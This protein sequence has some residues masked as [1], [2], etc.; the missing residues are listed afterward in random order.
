[1][2]RRYLLNSIGTLSLLNFGGTFASKLYAQES[3]LSGTPI[4]NIK[5]PHL[6]QDA[7]APVVFYSPI[8]SPDALIKLLEVSQYKVS[9]KVGIKMTFSN[10]RD[11]AV[12]IDPMLI[13]PLIEKVKGTMIDSNYFDGA[14]NNTQAHLE[15]AKANG[16]DKAGPIEILD[17]EGEIELPVKGGYHLKTFITGS[18]LADYDSLISVVRFKGHNLPRYGGSMKNLSICLGTPRGAA[19]VHSGG[20]VTEYF[21]SGGG[22]VASES[23]AD[24]VKSA[25]DFKPGRWIFFNI[26]DALKPQRRDSCK[27]AVDIGDIGIVVSTDPVACDQA[28]VD[29]VYGFAPDDSTRKQWENEHFVDT[30]E[31]AEKIGVGSTRYRLQV[32]R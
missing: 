14:R 2:K 4:A 30:L 1:M 21:S 5:L 7:K 31:M 28:A 13:K 27:G 10:V 20:K 26:I 16:F 3:F 9:G 23:M 25:L 32:I 6:T 22:K 12:K 8:V 29:M 19:Q 17:S 11:S 15:T 18:K 24:A